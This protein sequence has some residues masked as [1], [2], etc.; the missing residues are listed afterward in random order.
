MF[1]LGNAE[2]V[3]PEGHPLRKVKTLVDEALRRISS[4]LD[5]MYAEGGRDSIPPE[6]LLKGQLLI[7]FYSIRSERQLCEQLRY[8]LLYRW[9]LDMSATEAVFVPTV[10]THNRDRLLKHEVAQEFFGEVVRAA[11]KARLMS[12]DHF[13]V[14]GTLIEAWAS[15]KSFRP[16]DEK[17]DDND[18]TPPSGGDANRW[19]DFHG[20]RL[21][22]ETHESKT[23]PDA[24]LY[25]KSKGSGAKLC[26]GLHVLMENRNGLVRDVRITEANG[27]TERSAALDR[28]D[29]LKRPSGHSITVG[30]DKGYDTADFVADCRARGATPHVAQNVNG[31]ASAIDRRT[32][33]HPG[34]P[35]SLR[36]RMRIEEIFGWVK[37]T[38][39]YRKT[40]LRGIVKNQLRAYV[41]GA[42]YNLLRVAKLLAQPQAA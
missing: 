29:A 2:A 16:K 23:D 33:K 22:N 10:F 38:G 7:A 25:R 24:K 26:F 15:M 19:V 12:E 35:V 3:V 36:K 39:A 42:A 41:I 34:Y 13:S 20:E 8:N 28:L 31:R 5:A 14:D 17:N 40:M 11:T 37:T 6:R 21:S 32:T 9:F 30:G 1:V 4:T 27:K 18:K